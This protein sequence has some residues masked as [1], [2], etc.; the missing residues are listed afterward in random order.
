MV[1][2]VADAMASNGMKAAGYNYVC[3]DDCWAGP[4]DNNGAP[5]GDKSRFPSGMKALADYVHSKGL[6][7]GLYTCAGNYT[8]KHGRPGSWGHFDQDAQTFADWG[9]DF[10]KMDWCHHPSLPPKTVYSEFRDSINKTGRQMVF[11]ICEWGEDQPWTWGASTGNMWRVGP[12]HLPFWWMPD[13][14]Q[15]QSTSGIIENM[16]GKSPYSGPGG[17][18]DPD[19]LMTGAP[20]MTHLQ[21]KSEFS[22]WALWAAPLIV[23]TDVRIMS[24]KGDI[25]LNPEVI[26]VNQDSLCRAGERLFNSSM[27]G[28]V[29]AKPLSDGTFV[30]ILYN[31]DLIESLTVT[32]MFEWLWPGETSVIYASIRDLWD[33]KDLGNYGKGYASLVEGHGVVML[34]I[35]KL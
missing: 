7:L 25:L 8:C 24:D 26:A 22:F 2:E 13:S 20:T 12:D 27:G 23:A 32:V 4:R 17:W 3:L 15:V 29:W 14:T 11:S 19:F 34:K 1:H 31:P 10:V 18:N 35:R 30:V 21:S 33:H 16:A 5:T 28:E 9:A 6:K